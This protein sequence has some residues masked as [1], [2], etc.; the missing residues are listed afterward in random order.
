VPQRFL[1]KGLLNLSGKT[2]RIN[3]DQVLDIRVFG[4]ALT[5]RQRDNGIVLKRC[6]EAGEELRPVT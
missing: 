2:F 6:I 1:K 4:C 5:G 3:R